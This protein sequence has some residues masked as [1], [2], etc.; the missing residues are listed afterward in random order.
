MK[1]NICGKRLVF[2]EECSRQWVCPDW[3]RHDAEFEPA[4][5]GIFQADEMAMRDK[6][7][8]EDY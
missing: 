3:K 8:A 7:A 2:S 1:C 5:S 4:L 6:M